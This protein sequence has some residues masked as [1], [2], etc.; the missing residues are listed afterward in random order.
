MT[1]TQVQPDLKRK[2][3]DE[4]STD[5]PK[6]Q[7]SENN[8]NNAL[9]RKAEEEIPGDSD[10]KN[11]KVDDEESETDA[12]EEEDGDPH[13]VH[14]KYLTKDVLKACMRFSEVKEIPGKC[15][16][17]YINFDWD[18]FRKLLKEDAPPV[19]EIKQRLYS[20]TPW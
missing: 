10:V 13:F 5:E 14:Y 7:T 11:Q 17:V 2:A 4:V 1:D 3:E 16:V 19:D 20:I 9:K 6:V 15:S 18:L 8:E 12:E